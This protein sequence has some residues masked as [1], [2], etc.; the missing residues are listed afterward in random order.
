[1]LSSASVASPCLATLHLARYKWNGRISLLIVVIH[2]SLFCG[3]PGL[4]SWVTCKLMLLVEE[5]DSKS[6][7]G[8]CSCFSLL[9]LTWR[10]ARSIPLVFVL[11]ILNV[12]E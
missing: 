3:D 5:K 6:P 10:L 7:S 4:A 8:V 9:L 12:L 1:M 11:A 2:P